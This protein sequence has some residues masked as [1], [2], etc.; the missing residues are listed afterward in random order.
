MSEDSLDSVWEEVGF[1]RWQLMVLALNGLS[2]LTH[3][4]HRE[5][6]FLNLVESNQ[7]WIEIPLF[8]LIWH[9]MDFRLLQN[10]LQK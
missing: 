9:Q 5:I 4:R 7:V 6:F 2:G 8:S 10:Q 3:S 1:G